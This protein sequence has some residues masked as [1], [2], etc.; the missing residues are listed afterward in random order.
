MGRRIE[1]E[2]VH[3]ENSKPQAIQDGIA[4]VYVEKG[5]VYP[6]AV[7]ESQHNLIQAMVGGICDPLRVIRTPIGESITLDQLRK[8]E[9]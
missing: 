8:G 7:T 2:L 5:T 3:M 6:V 4:I 1:K 9:E